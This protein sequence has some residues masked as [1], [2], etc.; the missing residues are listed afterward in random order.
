ML[1]QVQAE[2]S[3]KKQKLQCG[4][5]WFWQGELIHPWTVELGTRILPKILAASDNDQPME[6][7]GNAFFM[8]LKIQLKNN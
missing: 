6:Q 3:E 2:V 1:Q 4:W 7:K 8:V 5:V